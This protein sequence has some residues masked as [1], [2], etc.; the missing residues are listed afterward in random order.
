MAVK[1]A[2]VAATAADTSTYTTLY[3]CP[4]DKTAVVSSLVATNCSGSD[5]LIRVGLMSSAGTPAVASGQF[6]VYDTTVLATDLWAFTIGLTIMSGQYLRVS[7]SSASVN[8]TL[9]FDEE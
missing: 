2:Q 7:A 6:I 5:A 8:F 3:T 4:V 9:C 1:N